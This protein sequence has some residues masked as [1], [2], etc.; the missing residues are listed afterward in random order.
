MT[1]AA[2]EKIASRKRRLAAFEA[3]TFASASRLSF[4]GALSAHLADVAAG[5]V[6]G[7]RLA[8]RACQTS[9][10]VPASLKTGVR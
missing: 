2:L 8:T 6:T 4:R 3:R 1:R 5:A 7:H 9:G 10:Y